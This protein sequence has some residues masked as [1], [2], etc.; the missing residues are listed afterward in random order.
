MNDY[1]MRTQKRLL[2]FGMLLL[3]LTA[4]KAYSQEIPLSFDVENRGASCAKPILPSFEDL[5]IVRPLTDPFEWSDGSGRDTTL[6]GWICRRNEIMSE[7]QNYEVGPKPERPDTI[8]ASFNRSTKTIT[9]NVTD[10]G[11]TL[12]LTSQVSIPEGDGPFPLIIGMGGPTGS[13]P[14]DIFSSR[15]IA[16]VGFN[17]SQVMAHKQSRG[18][19]PINALYPELSYMGAYAAWP[20]GVSR[21]IDG[22]EILK[23]SL[24]F[25]LSRI[26]VSGCSFAGKMALFVGAFDE[27]IALTIVQESGGG[28]AAAWRVSETLTG[29]ENLA[30]TDQTWFMPSMWKFAGSNVS[31]LPHDHHE[32]IALVAPRALLYL[33]NPPQVWLAEESGYV[34]CRAASRVWKTLGVPER[35]GFSSE[36]NHSHCGVNDN[37]VKAI[38]AFVDRFLIGDKSVSTDYELNIYPNVDYKAWTSWWGSG[39]PEFGKRDANGSE[40]VWVE[41][42]CGTVGTNWEILKD[43]FASNKYGVRIKSKLDSTLQ[44]NAQKN[45]PTDEASIIT[46]PFSVKSDD[47]F[48][49]FARMV[50][51]DEARNTNWFKVD[52]S[53]FSKLSG[54]ISP[55]WTWTKLNSFKLAPGEHTLTIAFSEKNVKIDKFC[56]SNNPNSPFFEGEESVNVCQPT[57]PSG[58]SE[59]ISKD[60]FSLGQNYPNPV[61]H[62]TNIPFY[63]SKK[64]HVSLKVFNIVGTEIAELA[65]KEFS[66]GKHIVEFDSSKLSKGVYFYTLKAEDFS[67]SQKMIIQGE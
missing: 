23:D 4:S 52:D 56:I 9:V 37:K 21:L 41:V 39:V 27:R 62:M 60:G 28:G 55:G 66:T 49:I 38:E 19:E 22:L 17:F 35:F 11:K 18:T 7:I 61:T 14:G 1:K 58:T 6:E 67:A 24:N 59:K 5:P 57:I 51:P 25:D 64:S 63:L 36:G 33:G 3:G 34:S 43:N 40:S 48:N 54:S 10:N 29:V 45:A 13:L 47:T 12:T 46:V 26:A 50:C 44:A 53:E 8:T 2:V 42:E 16:T 15:K 30:N 65:G 31:K 32:L 20:W